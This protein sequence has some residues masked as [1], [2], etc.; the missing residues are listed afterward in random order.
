MK[1]YQPKMFPSKEYNKTI[2]SA[3]IIWPSSQSIAKLYRETKDYNS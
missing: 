3:S 1:N 2:I